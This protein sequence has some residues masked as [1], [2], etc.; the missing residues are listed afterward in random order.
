MRDLAR[1]LRFA[2]VGASVALIY[3]ALYVGF[4]QLGW[5]QVTANASAFLLAVIVQY[6]AQAGFTFRVRLA[7]GSQ[8]LRFGWMIGWGLLTSAILTGLLAPAFDMRPSAAAILVAL[9]LPVQNYVLMS[10]WVFRPLRKRLDFT[11]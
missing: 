6:V 11:S 7:V 2:C 9:I 4:L 10:R 8:I 3:V 5:W 1:L